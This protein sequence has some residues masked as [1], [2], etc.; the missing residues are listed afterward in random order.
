MW[1]LMNVS[2]NFIYLMLNSL[3][4]SSSVVTAVDHYKIHSSFCLKL[5]EIHFGKI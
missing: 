1:S 5:S 2:S 3:V 4:L